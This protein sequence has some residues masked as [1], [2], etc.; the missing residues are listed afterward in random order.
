LLALTMDRAQHETPGQAAADNCH[1]RDRG[2]FQSLAFN[3]TAIRCGADFELATVVQ[4][5][6]QRFADI[7]ARY[8]LETC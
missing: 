8:Y 2:D 5:S 3:L 7:S 4:P 6:R 1:R